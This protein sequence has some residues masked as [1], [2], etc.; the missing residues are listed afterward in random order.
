[1]STSKIG[2]CHEPFK[3]DLEISEQFSICVPFNSNYSKNGLHMIGRA[4]N[5]YKTREGKKLQEDVQLLAAHAMCGDVL[6]KDTKIWVDLFIEKPNNRS[7]AAN[8]LDLIFDGLKKGIGRDD[9][10]FSLY[11]LDWAI[12]PVDPSIFIAVG[13]EK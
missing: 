3:S 12:Q 10:W 2:L 9:R 11:R 5:M 8:V 13:L 1:M 7:D 4:G 6:P